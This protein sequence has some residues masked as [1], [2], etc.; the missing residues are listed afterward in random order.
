[1]LQGLLNDISD[2]DGL[3]GPRQLQS[4]PYKI[5]KSEKR[6]FS[7]FPTNTHSTLRLKIPSKNIRKPDIQRNWIS[8]NNCMLIFTN[9]NCNFEAIA[10]NE[11]DE[12]FTIHKLFYVNLADPAYKTICQLQRTLFGLIKKSKIDSRN[13]I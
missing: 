8:I 4:A 13:P 12:C 9:E 3:K 11:I 10:Q 5:R 2:R 7:H 1:M 6:F